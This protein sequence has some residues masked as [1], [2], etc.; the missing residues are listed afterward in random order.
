MRPKLEALKFLFLY[1][2]IILIYIIADYYDA[3]IIGRY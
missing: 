1:A 3:E 2:L